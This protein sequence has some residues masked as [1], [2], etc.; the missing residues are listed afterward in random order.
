VDAV[1]PVGSIFSIQPPAVTVVNVSLMLTVTG[2]TTVAQLAGP[3][4]TALTG[5]IDT[6]PIGAP[7][8][9][10]RVS[11]LAYAVSGAI[12]NVTQVQLNG[13]GIDIA[14]AAN[15]VVKVGQVAVN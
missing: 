8:P 1:R 14:P 6:L 13:A 7:L 3:V 9:V 2:S 12:S 5:F 15:G 11:Q 4:A 10:S